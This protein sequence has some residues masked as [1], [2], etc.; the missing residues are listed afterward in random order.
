MAVKSLAVVKLTATYH[1]PPA[2]VRAVVTKAVVFSM[3]GTGERW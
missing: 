2:I 3:Y 1:E